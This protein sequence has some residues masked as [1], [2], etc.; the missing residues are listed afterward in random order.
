MTLSTPY[1]RF[2]AILAENKAQ[3]GGHVCGS[4]VSGYFETRARTLQPGSP[5]ARL[6]YFSQVTPAEPA[7]QFAETR[8]IRPHAIGTDHAAYEIA[9]K[10]VEERIH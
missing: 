10:S 7:G 1:S 9:R 4:V 3:L 8:R 5:T 2:H 6:E